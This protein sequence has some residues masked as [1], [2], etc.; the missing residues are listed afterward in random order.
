MKIILLAS[1]VLF[2]A[3]AYSQHNLVA[4]DDSVKNENMLSYRLN[5]V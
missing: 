1:T 3:V 2:G 4:A 5:E